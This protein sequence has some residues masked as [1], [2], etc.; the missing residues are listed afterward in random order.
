MRFDSV[1][2]RVFLAQ[3]QEFA[4]AAFTLVQMVPRTIV[5]LAPLGSLTSSSSQE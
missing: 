1:A 2:G 4:A 3:L 5:P